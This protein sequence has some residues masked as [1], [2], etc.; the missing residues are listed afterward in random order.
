LTSK[1]VSNEH[2]KFKE[3]ASTLT[4][5]VKNIFIEFY[6]PAIKSISDQ[7]MKF[8]NQMVF[9]VIQG[10][11]YVEIH[12]MTRLSLLTKNSTKVSGYVSQQDYDRRKSSSLLLLSQS[13]SSS[14]NLSD[15]SLNSSRLSNSSLNRS[16]S[17]NNESIALRENFMSQSSEKSAR[18]F[19]GSDSNINLNR[20]PSA[21][22]TPSTNLMKAKRQIS[23]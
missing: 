3:F 22:T 20:P 4:R 11:D 10:Q 19:G 8:A 13:C 2:E 1:K 7:L 18:K 6:N 16:T 14:L 9:Y 17:K 12:K 5:L 23:F 21:A 15:N